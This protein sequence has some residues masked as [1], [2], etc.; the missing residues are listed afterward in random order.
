RS[1]FSGTIEFVPM[2]GRSIERRLAA[3]LSADVEGYSRL[4]GDD[5]VAT[6]RAITEYRAVI[7]S[8]VT[9][10]GV[11]VVDAPGD[12]V[13]AEFSSVVDAVQCAVDIQ[14]QLEARNAELPPS[15]RMRFRI[16]I[17]LGDVIIEGERL[18]GDGVNIAARLESLAEPGG[19]CISGTVYE[20]VENKLALTYEYLGEQ[21]DK[22][23][24]KP[25]RV[26]RVEGERAAVARRG[27]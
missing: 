24:A 26:W 20:H 27:P 4:M 12:N 21:T 18:Y 14:R 22:N 2:G 9:G 17:N 7:A 19:I 3:I 8:T 15:R 11:G 23:I 13:L 6:V 16:G 5:E 10:H 25:V 1:A